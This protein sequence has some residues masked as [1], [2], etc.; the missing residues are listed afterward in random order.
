[1]P[2][3]KK[4]LVGV[5]ITQHA[6]IEAQRHALDAG[7]GAYWDGKQLADCPAEFLPKMG[8][9]RLYDSWVMGFRAAAVADGG[10]GS[11]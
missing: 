10:G 11:D 8:D 2:V 5:I 3:D 7:A 6:V 1:M 9:A 4:H